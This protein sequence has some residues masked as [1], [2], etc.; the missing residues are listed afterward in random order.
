M[1]GFD[2]LFVWSGGCRVVA[3]YWR[4][5]IPDDAWV[6]V[7]DPPSDLGAG[8]RPIWDGR[9]LVVLAGQIDGTPVDAG[10]SFRNG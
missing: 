4:Y 3:G 2:R 9:E 1:K 6:P 5:D 10:A 7:S 8:A